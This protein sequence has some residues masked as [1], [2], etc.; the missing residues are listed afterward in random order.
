MDRT[1]GTRCTV[2]CIAVRGTS[3]VPHLHTISIIYLY[4]NLYYNMI[5]LSISILRLYTDYR[6]LL[7]SKVH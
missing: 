7:K 2:A 3:D 6:Q 1:N 5:Y 4:S